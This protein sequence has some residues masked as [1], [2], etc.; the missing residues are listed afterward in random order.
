VGDGAAS[1]FDNHGGN[2]TQTQELTPSNPSGADLFGYSVALNYV[3]NGALVGATERNGTDGSAFTFSGYPTLTQRR[4]L[5]DP[6]AGS[7]AQYGFSVAMDAL[8][9]QLLTGAPYQNGIQGAA[10]AVAN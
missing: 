8:G 4:E 2:W 6:V 10:W 1:V 3:D 9:D 5:D 7:G